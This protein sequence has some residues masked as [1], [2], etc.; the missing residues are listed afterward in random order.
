MYIEYLWLYEL[1]MNL[2]ASLS[3][4]FIT[5]IIYKVVASFKSTETVRIRYT[6]WL[7]TNVGQCPDI[8]LLYIDQL[9]DVSTVD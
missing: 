4:C 2:Y 6:P 9:S 5:I 7:I 1:F 8:R 3:K